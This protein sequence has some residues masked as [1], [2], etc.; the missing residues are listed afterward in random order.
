[1]NSDQVFEYA[2]QGTNLGNDPLVSGNGKPQGIANNAEGTRTWVVDKTGAV[3]VYDNAGA[4]LGSWTATGP[5]TFDGIATDGESIWIVDRRSDRVWFFDGAAGWTSGA[6]N[7]DGVF[8]LAKGNGA[9]RGITTD[10]TNL[11]IV[12]SRTSKDEVFKY[13]IGGQLVGRWQIDSANSTPTGITI[14]PNDVRHIWIVDSGTDRVYQY[15]DG[16]NLT[17]GTIAASSSFA[18]DA[19][20]TNPQGIAD[21]RSSDAVSTNASSV[22]PVNVAIDSVTRN[23]RASDLRANVD[24]VAQSSATASIDEPQRRFAM[25]Q[26]TFLVVGDA[27]NIRV[28]SEAQED[29]QAHD[30]S[31]LDIVTE[32]ADGSGEDLLSLATIVPHEAQ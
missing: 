5:S 20:N 21:P 24:E 1:M 14:D 16:A 18:L 13:T 2:G 4:V 25:H 32:I 22:P 23:H 27:L 17:S 15:D 28:P 9:S 31:L 12:N 3:F 8:S 26:A 6:R 30:K 11:W 29:E 7:A 19:A 10:G